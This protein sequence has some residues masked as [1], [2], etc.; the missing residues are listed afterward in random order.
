MLNIY[1]FHNGRVEERHARIQTIS[2][3]LAVKT[4]A[5]FGVDMIARQHPIKCFKLPWLP[6]MDSAS[7]ETNT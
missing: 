7:A 2:S 6:T 1:T 3:G 4:S 5:R